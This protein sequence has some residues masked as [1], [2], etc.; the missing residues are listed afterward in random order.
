[1]RVLLS[2]PVVAVLSSCCLFQSLSAALPVELAPK[3]FTFNSAGQY[4]IGRGDVLFL[5]FPG[6]ASINGEYIVSQAGFLTIPLL[7]LLKA[8]GISEKQLKRKIELRMKGLFKNSAVLLS[9]TK[10]SS[11]TVTVKG[12][13]KKPGRFSLND[14]ASV[15]DVIYRSAK[16]PSI[17]LS[18]VYL[19]RRDMTGRAIEFWVPRERLASVF[20]E[21]TDQLEVR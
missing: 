11:F 16:G 4:T 14:K 5:R 6:E 8:E 9:L 21:R 13:V 15:M 12:R 7:G 10:K 1:M 2:A 17:S 19:K 18:G 3:G 20:V